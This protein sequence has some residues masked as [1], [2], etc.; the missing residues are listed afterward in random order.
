M[1]SASDA[2]GSTDCVNDRYEDRFPGN[3][4]V[5]K[6]KVVKAPWVA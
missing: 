2:V 5:A 1:S 4:D 3:A 6:L